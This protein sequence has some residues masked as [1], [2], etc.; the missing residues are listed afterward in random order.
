MKTY[1]SLIAE[2]CKTKATTSNVSKMLEVLISWAQH[3]RTGYYSDLA[4]A[5]ENPGITRSIGDLL[6]Y[7]EDILEDLRRKLEVEIPSLNVMVKKKGTD[8]PGDGLSYVYEDYDKMDKKGKKVFVDGALSQ[9]YNFPKWDAVLKAL[10]LNHIAIGHDE[11]D[12]IIRKGSFG[13]GGEGAKHKALKEYVLSHPS[14][15]GIR[16]VALAESEHVLLSGDRLDVYFELKNGTR[17][18]VEVKSAISDED[19]I[20]RGLYQCVKYKS[21]MEAECQVHGEMNDNKTILVIES[22]LSHDNLMVK[23]ILGVDV[24]ENFRF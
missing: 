2:H 1:T 4:E 10:G 17:I 14:Q 9:V 15:V 12:A 11:V 16:N 5:I 7:A 19:D 18:A 6:G 8:L 21:I 13:H 22:S 24:I 3:G 23:E 20:R